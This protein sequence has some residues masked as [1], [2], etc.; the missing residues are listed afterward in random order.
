MKIRT[1]LALLLGISLALAASDA[2]AHFIWVKLVPG[3][4]GELAAKAYFGETPAPDRDELLDKISNVKFQV[5][6]ATGEAQPVSLKKSGEG[7][8]AELAVPV[9][10]AAPCSL[11]ATCDYGVYDMHDRS[12][13][14]QY[15]AKAVQAKSANDVGRLGP[16]AALKLDIVPSCESGQLKAVVLWEGKPQKGLSVQVIGP[17]KKR[18]KLETNEQG[19]V[20]F[21]A[22]QGGAYALLASHTEKDRAGERNGRKYASV[23]H[24]CTLTVDLPTSAPTATAGEPKNDKEAMAVLA[25]ARNAR[26]VWD[27]FPG[28]T[29]DVLVKVEQR[30]AQGKLKVSPEGRVE[31]ELADLSKEDLAWAKQHLRSLAQHRMPDGSLGDGASFIKE[32]GN[33]P[34]GQRVRLAEEIMG[35][36][37][38]IKDDV[39]RQV[40]RVMGKQKLVITVLEVSRNPEGKYLP[41]VFNV[42]M[43]DNASGTL[44]G[45]Q[46]VTHNWL[47]VGQFDLP[48]RIQEV[49]CR[50]GGNQVRTIEFSAHQLTPVAN[51]S[52]QASAKR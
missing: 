42:S 2:Q 16:A 8:H 3:A 30:T 15:Y 31:L 7:D 45:S 26:A 13:L 6:G 12:V 47:R 41:S 11:E 33:H 44:G 4:N 46:T 38:R 29:A 24:Y 10:V 37:Y 5:R 27:H 50:Q 35:S 32:E 34:L 25:R 14:L 43:W 9:G 36:E 18:Q 1:T 52:V 40:N 39:V 22:P 28:F 48:Q 21:A 49:D 19:A 20:S 51:K 23:G 17:D